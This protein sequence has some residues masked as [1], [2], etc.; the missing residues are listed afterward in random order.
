M[1]AESHPLIT[2]KLWESDTHTH[3]YTHTPACAHTHTHRETERVAKMRDRTSSPFASL[4]THT[5]THTFSLL[6]SHTPHT[7][8]LRHTNTLTRS[9]TH[10]HA[11]TSFF[12][13]SDCESLSSSPPDRSLLCLF[14]SLSRTSCGFAGRLKRADGSDAEGGF[15]HQRE[16]DS[17]R[18]PLDARTTHTRKTHKHT[19]TS[20]S[21]SCV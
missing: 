2:C 9:H 10:T 17:V 14:F 21:S 3:T 4:T 19:H 6:H 20:C 1:A 18:L 12:R 11:H 7:H 5:Y 15:D 16:M 13:R 8:T